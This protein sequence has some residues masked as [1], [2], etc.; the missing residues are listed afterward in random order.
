MVH[1]KSFTSFHLIT[2]QLNSEDNHLEPGVGPSPVGKLARLE[3]PYSGAKSADSDP[4]KFLQWAR[5]IA[6]WKRQLFVF[7]KTPISSFKEFDE[8]GISYAHNCLYI[9]SK[10]VSSSSSSSSSSS[11]GYQILTLSIHSHYKNR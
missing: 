9:C 6:L 8:N 11:R 7:L 5:C 10:V 1:G 2:Y 4:E 3:L